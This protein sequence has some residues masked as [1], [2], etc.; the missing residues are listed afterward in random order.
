MQWHSLTS[1]NITVHVHKIHI[2]DIYEKKIDEKLCVMHYA[3][4]CKWN[5]NMHIYHFCRFKIGF[6]S[7]ELKS[8]RSSS[9]LLYLCAFL[10]TGPKVRYNPLRETSLACTLSYHENALYIKLHKILTSRASAIMKINTARLALQL[11]LYNSTH[12]K[13]TVFPKSLNLESKMAWTELLA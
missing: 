6:W 13:N 5:I 12:E 4:V 10:T 1:K 9:L 11:C 7:E 3:N 8:E 2:L